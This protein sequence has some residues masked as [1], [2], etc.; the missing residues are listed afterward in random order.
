MRGRDLVA[1]AVLGAVVASAVGVA[2]AAI[3]DG[4]GV[5]HACFQNVTSANKPVKLLDTA[6]TATCPSGWK[7]VS[8]NQTGQRGLPG[9]AGTNGTSIIVRTR[10]SASTNVPSGPDG[11]SAAMPLTGATWT[12]AA[13]HINQ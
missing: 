11:G 8:W 9:Q 5:V 10:L 2:Y 7:A 3:P 6:K 12:Q 13:G 4:G 1:G